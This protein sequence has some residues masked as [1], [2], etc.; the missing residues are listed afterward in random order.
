LLEKT[1][2]LAKW[3]RSE[4]NKIEGL[5]AFGRELTG[6][7]G[8]FDFDE[9]K[10]GINVCGLGLTGYE[11]EAKLRAEYKIQV[12]MSDLCNVLAIITIGDSKANLEA[13]VRALEQIAKKS[14]VRKAR[15]RSIIWLEPEVAVAPREAFYRPKKVVALDASAGKISGEIIMA[16]PPGIPVI[17]IGERIS[18]EIIDYIKVLKSEKCQLQGT[19]DQKVDFIRVLT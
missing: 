9:T 4:I 7:P 3:A 16:Y 1:I 12:E 11:V 5:Y 13:F 15:C 8:C 17:G 2:D 10:I 18:K 6:S 14:A 19:S